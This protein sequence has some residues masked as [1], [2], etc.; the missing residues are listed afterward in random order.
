MACGLPV[1]TTCVTGV[2][3]ILTPGVD[4]FVIESGDRVDD[5][6]GILLS[7]RNPGRR[8][9]VGRA[10]RSTAERHSLDANLEQHLALYESVLALKRGVRGESLP[11]RA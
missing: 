6:A 8:E 10:A 7:L 3:E 11:A 4:G 9:A 1:I 5:I 2:A